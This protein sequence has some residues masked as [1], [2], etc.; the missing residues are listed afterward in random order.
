MSSPEWIVGVSGAS[1]T[2]YA[3]RLLE[4]LT[5]NGV[6]VHLVVSEAAARV[7]KEEDGITVSAQSPKAASF[8]DVEADRIIPYN[9]KDIGAA[10][11]SGSVRVQG[12]VIAP[13][14][15]ATLGSIATATPTNLLQRAADVTLKEGRR[16]I[17][18]PRETPMHAIHLRHMAD[19]AA[20]G[21][22]VVP[23]MPG[24][25]HQPKT[26]ED[27][28]DMMVMKITDQMGLSLDLVPRW[29]SQPAPLNTEAIHD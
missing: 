15:M 22:R 11:A 29:K 23:A 10:I 28:V 8:G 7:M 1:G 20:M 24:F 9:I 5:Q 26:L 4:V 14:S 18:V 25:Y 13:M 19:L 6:V 16:L 12:M 17:L 3:R 2:V 27:L 21:V